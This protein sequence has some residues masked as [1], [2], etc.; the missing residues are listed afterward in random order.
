M[1]NKN[2]IRK[3]TINK[4]ASIL[5]CIR[6]N[7]QTINIVKSNHFSVRDEQR[8]IFGLQIAIEKALAVAVQ[9]VEQWQAS[10]KAQL[11]GVIKTANN[12]NIVFS[13]EPDKRGNKDVDFVFQTIIIKRD[14]VSKNPGDVVVTI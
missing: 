12:L 6:G 5:K 7:G 1:T 14:F 4:R 11:E 13:V 2:G 9:L 8:G 10:G 3:L